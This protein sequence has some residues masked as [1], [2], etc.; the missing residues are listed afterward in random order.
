LKTK[1]TS[2]SRKRL[3]FER[4]PAVA[5]VVAV[6]FQNLFGNAAWIINLAQWPPDL[7]NPRRAVAI[8]LKLLL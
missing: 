8:S 2:L 7:G 5:A 6:D 4:L 1:D 3:D